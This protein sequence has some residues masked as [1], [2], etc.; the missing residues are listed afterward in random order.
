MISAELQ[1]KTGAFVAGFQRVDG[2]MRG[3]QQR[4]I[5]LEGAFR[6]FAW[7]GGAV[8]GAVAAFGAKM[9]G[10]FDLGGEVSDVAAN[11]G[12]A[13]SEVMLLRQA[14]ANAGLGA[15]GLGGNIARLQKALAGTN[16]EGQSTNAAL[17]RLGLAAGKLD[18]LTA[19]EQI[20]QLQYAFAG[21]ED[22]AQRTA[23]AMELFGKSGTKMLALLG[24]SNAL[25]LA[26]EQVGALG[27][28]MD[29]NAGK[30]DNLSDNLNTLAGLKMDQFFAGFAAQVVGAE[31][32][33]ERLS[34]VDF[35]HVG[36]AIAEAAQKTWEWA[37][38]AQEGWGKLMGIEW[39]MKKLKALGLR[40]WGDLMED[41]QVDSLRSKNAGAELGFSKRMGDEGGQVL[42][43][44]DVEAAAELARKKL[45]DV[46]KEWEGYDPQRIEAVKSE[47]GTHIQMLDMQAAAL[48]GVAT[49]MDEQA[50][51]TKASQEAWQ[52]LADTY[53]KWSE[54]R[55]ALAATVPKFY[56]NEEMAAAETP[57][58]KRKILTGRLGVDS[59]AAMDA[60]ITA[61]SKKLAPGGG[62]WSGTGKEMAR[63]KE[64]MS[65]RSQVAALD[66]G[67]AATAESDKA[68]RDGRD[69]AQVERDR[70]G[71]D[72]EVA[73]KRRAVEEL[74]DQG[75]LPTLQTL[76]DSS[77]KL[78]LGGFGASNAGDIQ[79]LMADRQQTAN[80]LL[81]QIRRLLEGR[82]EK[83]TSELVFG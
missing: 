39:A 68:A 41:A 10:V 25:T 1:L 70:A 59:V 71:V 24:D 57:E 29:A 78:G 18:N 21:I 14:F 54:E 64:L 76:G 44:K 66:R 34:K 4:A 45:Q 60:E 36:G 19:V 62:T 67:I 17:Q 40:S 23:T 7:A 22:P 47:L 38:G 16:E 43:L 65:G 55:V 53:K 72:K 50:D 2:M 83:V 12:M 58:A 32:G 3:M 33:V 6:G 46:N 42:L 28:L 20:K 82:K 51:S 31:D 61:L 52:K 56:E 48:R 69:Q 79:R 80:G 75:R 30:F 5:A 27:A 15:D 9:K 49:A 77:R 81:E 74:L 11:T 37:R 63:L 26:G 73:E 35:T 8:F 13:A